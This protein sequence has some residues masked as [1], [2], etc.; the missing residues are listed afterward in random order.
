LPVVRASISSL[1][2]S[3]ANRIAIQNM[4]IRFQGRQQLAK[5][6]RTPVHHFTLHKIAANHYLPAN[7]L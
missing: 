7:Y 6:E 2:A 5:E 1:P 4:E 3:L